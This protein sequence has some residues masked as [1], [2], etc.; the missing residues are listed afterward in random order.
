MQ[1]GGSI[2]APLNYLDVMPTL[3]TAANIAGRDDLRLDGQNVLP[4]LRG[5]AATDREFYSYVGQLSNEREQLM[6]MD[7]DWKLIIIGPEPLDRAALASS[8]TLLFDLGEDP[9]EQRDVASE[10]PRIVARLTQQA[11]DFRALQ[12]EEHVPLFYRPSS[13]DFIPPRWIKE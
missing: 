1:G 5:E 9:S 4:I 7:R 12:P 2:S 8:Q 6:A 10:H 13:R 3:M 11:L